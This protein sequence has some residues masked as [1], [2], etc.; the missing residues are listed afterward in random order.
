MKEVRDGDNVI[1]IFINVADRS[2]GMFS[3]ITFHDSTQ[4]QWVAKL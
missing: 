3:F 2:V 1:D 4:T